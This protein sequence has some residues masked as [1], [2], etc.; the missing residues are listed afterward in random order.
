MPLVMT[1]SS[2]DGPSD[3]PLADVAT[4]R[5]FH[6]ARSSSRSFPSKGSISAC[7]RM[8]SSPRCSVQLLRNCETELTMVETPFLTGSV[9][10]PGHLASGVQVR[11]EMALPTWVPS[12]DPYRQRNTH[13]HT[14]V[15]EKQQI[16]ESRT[17]SMGLPA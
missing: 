1:K 6:G 10:A 3:L 4:S 16:R 2:M 8:Q 13:I 12:H 17:K 15:N 7:L 11:Q 14:R 5:R 9:L